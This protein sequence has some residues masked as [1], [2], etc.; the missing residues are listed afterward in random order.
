MSNTFVN[1][2]QTSFD[3]MAKLAYEREGLKLP[4]TVRTKTGVVGK[5]H[6]FVFYGAPSAA[7]TKSQYV[8]Y[9][10]TG[11]GGT[12]AFKTATLV[13]NDWFD[14]VDKVDMASSSVDD[15]GYTA[16]TAAVKIGQ[17]TDNRITAA[18]D[19]ATTNTILSASSGLTK[20]K[21]L[22]G[23]EILN[24]G[25]VPFADRY[26]LVDAKQWT[27]LLKIEEFASGDYVGGSTQ[28]LPWLTNAN[29]RIWLG[30]TFIMFPG[31]PKLVNDR[32]CL[33]YHRNAVGYAQALAMQ[34]EVAWVA[35]RDSWIIK[36]TCY[37]GA[38]AIDP[39][40]IVRILAD[41]SI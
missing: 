36:S 13:K 34:N 7:T 40:G 4:M 14:Y 25:N 20:D 1:V 27:D 22:K 15:V 37:D 38:V 39:A 8:S 31:L 11:L 16:T 35:D 21:V 3:D 18:L 10:D 6:K 30:M 9:A 17:A 28:P 41:E 2:Y 26:C 23:I 19:A 33:M 29:A 12:K 5:E 24:A 32:S